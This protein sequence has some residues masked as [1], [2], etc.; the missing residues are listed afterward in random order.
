[1]LYGA[2]LDGLEANMPKEERRRNRRLKRKYPARNVGSGNL[3]VTPYFDL[4]RIEVVPLIEYPE[5][6]P[7]NCCKGCI[8]WKGANTVCNCS[9]PLFEMM[10]G[11]GGHTI[12]MSK[13]TQ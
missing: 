1:L 4:D 11:T 9:L 7:Y 10:E 12:T 13:N 2:I 5:V 6:I 8:N 3:I